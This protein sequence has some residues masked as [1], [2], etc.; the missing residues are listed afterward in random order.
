VN[1]QEQRLN[2]PDVLAALVHGDDIPALKMAALDRA[3]ELYGPDAVLQIEEVGTIR[4]AC[5]PKGQ[6]CTC[7]YVRCLNLP[8]EDR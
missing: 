1:E 7:V 4:T 8:E 5:S 2:G 3:R 6:F